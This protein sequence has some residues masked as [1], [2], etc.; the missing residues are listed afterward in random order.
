MKNAR[1]QEVLERQRT[2][3]LEENR[4]QIGRTL[5]ILVEG[6]RG[7]GAFYGRADDH[8]T[9][10]LPET[11]KACLGEFIPVRIE[12]AFTGAL[13]GERVLPVASKGAL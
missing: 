6:K 13:A 7:D 5:T 4:R 8:R 12:E 2:I 10:V 9:V 3:A 1:L 11:E